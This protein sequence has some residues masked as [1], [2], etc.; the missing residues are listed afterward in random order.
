MNGY[1]CLGP[2][3][4]RAEIYAKTSLGARDIAAALWKIPANKAWRVS[5]HLAERADGSQVTHSTADL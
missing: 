2:N 3:G 1:I 5:A 4:K